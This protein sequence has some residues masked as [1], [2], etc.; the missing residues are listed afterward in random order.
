VVLPEPFGPM[1]PTRSP[2]MIV[3]VKSRTM[4][5]S[6]W[7]KLTPRALATSL[8]ERSDSSALSRTV[9]VSLPAGPAFQ[10]ERLERA[11]PPFV[12]GAA[13]P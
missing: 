7:E 8:P 9:P 2:R 10:P 11:N 3:V 4:T 13:G 12:S 5:R 6:P 1:R